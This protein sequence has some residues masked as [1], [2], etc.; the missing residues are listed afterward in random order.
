VVASS[1]FINYVD[2]DLCSG[3]ETCLDYC[4]FDALSMNDLG[5]VEV[6]TVRCVGCGVCVPQCDMEAMHLVKREEIDTPPVTEEEWMEERARRL[7]L[8]LSK[9]K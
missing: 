8:D 2:A 4:Q 3:C 7:G 6:S 5:V 1:S 9:V